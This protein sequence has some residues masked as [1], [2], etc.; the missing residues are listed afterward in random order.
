MIDGITD[1]LEVLM[2]GSDSTMGF[3]EFS[4]NI[5]G[6]SVYPIFEISKKNIAITLNCFYYFWMILVLAEFLV[7]D[8][9]LGLNWI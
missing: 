9:N 1:S 6:L 5:L 2:D 3:A 8:F 7:F 4:K